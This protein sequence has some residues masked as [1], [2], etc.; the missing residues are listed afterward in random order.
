MKQVDF[1][2]LGIVEL[3]FQLSAKQMVSREI[4]IYKILY[5]LYLTNRFIMFMV[6]YIILITEVLNLIFFMA[7]APANVYRNRFGNKSQRILERRHHNIFIY[8]HI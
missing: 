4:N 8:I 6:L 1:K 3:Q 5:I 7:Y 2:H